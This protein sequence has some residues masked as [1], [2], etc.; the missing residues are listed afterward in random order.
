MKK[1]LGA[2]PIAARESWIS[3]FAAFPDGMDS[4]LMTESAS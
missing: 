1:D 4:S 2:W 3:V